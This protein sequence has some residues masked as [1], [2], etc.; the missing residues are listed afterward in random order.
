MIRHLID[1]LKDPEIRAQV[2]FYGG[3]FLLFAVTLILKLANG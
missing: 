2:I 3:L 1:S